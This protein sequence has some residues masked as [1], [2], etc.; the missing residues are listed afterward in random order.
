[1]GKYW[2]DKNKS[3]QAFRMTQLGSKSS[4]RIFD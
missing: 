2:L 1:M 4:Y 3:K